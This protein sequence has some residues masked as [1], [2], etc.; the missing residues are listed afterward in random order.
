MNQLFNIQFFV[1]DCNSTSI[2]Q[3][4]ILFLTIQISLQ[5][6]YQLKNFC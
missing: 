6:Q 5:I 1:N 3:F 4:F 2:Y